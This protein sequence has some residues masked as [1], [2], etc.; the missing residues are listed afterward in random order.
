MNYAVDKHKGNHWVY[1]YATA[2]IKLVS[3]VN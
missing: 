3:G 1:K 2:T